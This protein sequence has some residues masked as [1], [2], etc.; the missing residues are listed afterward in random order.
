MTSPVLKTSYSNDS[1][2]PKLLVKSPYQ[3]RTHFP[4]VEMA[5]LKASIEEAGAIKVPII[6]RPESNQII[7]GERRKMI[8]IELGYKSVPIHWHTCTDREAE[9]FAA[10]ENVK[11]ADLNPIDETNMVIN[12]I[13]LRLDL[14]DRQ[15]AIDLIKQASSQSRSS[16]RLCK[17]TLKRVPEVDNLIP[18][19]V[20]SQLEETIKQF[21]KGALT[22]DSFYVNKMKLLT[23][24]EDI[25]K[26][27]QSGELEYSKGAAIA[28]VKDPELRHDLL[29]VAIEEDM[30]LADIKD[31][32]LKSDP[33]K[34]EK[35]E[36]KEAAKKAAT[37]K[38]IDSEATNGLDHDLFDVEQPTRNED[39]PKPK[40]VLPVVD[41]VNVDDA[42][43]PSIKPIRPTKNVDE[44]PLDLKLED[45]LEK[46]RSRL[47]A[48][49]FSFDI[50][51]KLEQLLDSV[52]ALMG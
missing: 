29:E 43:E 28:K 35:K 24:P 47:E 32:I 7:A 19:D 22:L 13:R 3:P 8:A 5:E 18:A 20:I 31:E 17:S 38:E 12:M 37:P 30:S 46:I 44:D 48:E 33:A 23:I 14:V 1:I 34:K 36:K 21:T 51:K 11:R 16:T 39:V 26:A 49:A 41:S 25:Q 40:K 52:V 4:P 2:D 10:F 15:A 42:I 27:I 9:E 6:V 45:T 50:K